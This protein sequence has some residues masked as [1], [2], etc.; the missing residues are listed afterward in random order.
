MNSNQETIRQLSEI[1]TLMERSSR[2]LSLS[3]LSGISAGVTAL[4]GAAFAFFYLGYD[5]RYFSL[6]RSL[7]GMEMAHRPQTLFFLM[8]D[9]L[10][11][12]L[13]ALASGIY[14]TTRKARQQKVKAW[15]ATTRRLL[16]NLLIPLAAGGTFCLA[17]LYYQLFFLIAPSSL[18][19]YGLALVHASKYTLPHVRYLGMAEMATGLVAS[20]M[21]GYG[22]IFWALGFGVWHIIYGAVMYCRFDREKAMI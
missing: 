2:F 1:R 9:A 14:F 13:V 16:I 17:L 8:A 15:D 20:F 12:L 10:I 21:V 7:A 22:L 18:I 4:A 3:G 11:V 5:E 6:G 19:F